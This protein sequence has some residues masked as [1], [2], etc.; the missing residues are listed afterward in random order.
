MVHHSLGKLDILNDFL[1]SVF[2][3]M[4]VF[5]QKAILILILTSKISNFASINKEGYKPQELKAL[6]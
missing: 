5:I 6:N 4:P 3:N 2:R 1:D